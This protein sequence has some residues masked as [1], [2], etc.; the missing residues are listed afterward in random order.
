MSFRTDV[1]TNHV[2]RLSVK[3]SSFHPVDRQRLETA[4]LRLLILIV[5]LQRLC[6]IRVAFGLGRME[7]AIQSE[8]SAGQYR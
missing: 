4:W 3:G 8:Y 7:E 2:K 5:I 1:F 6:G